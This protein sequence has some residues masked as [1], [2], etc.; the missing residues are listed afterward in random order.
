MVL[1]MTFNE[2]FSLKILFLRHHRQK[3][4]RFPNKNAQPEHHALSAG[5]G[6]PLITVR[7]R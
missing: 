1:S 4:M 7:L 3:K 5:D 6:E 2:S